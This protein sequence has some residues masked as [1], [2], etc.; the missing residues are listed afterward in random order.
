MHTNVTHV[1]TEGKKGKTEK[2]R[3][4]RGQREIINIHPRRLC[5]HALLDKYYGVPLE[6]K[7]VRKAHSNF[8]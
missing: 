1:L 2:L 4:V 5:V 6:K 8:Q 7:Y 3:G